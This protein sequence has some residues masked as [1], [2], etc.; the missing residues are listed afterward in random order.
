[1]QIDIGNIVSVV[2]GGLLVFAGHWFTSR[3]ST[4]VEMQKWKQEELREVR[5]DVVSFRE[6]RVKPI[7]EALDR[8]AHRWDAESH[9]ELAAIV[10]YHGE[11]VDVKSEKYKR[12]RHERRKKYFEQLKDDISAAS[13]IHDESVRRLVTQVLW[14]STEPE[15][16]PQFSERLQEAY[17]QLENWIFNPQLDYDSTRHRQKQRD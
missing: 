17:L 13:T 10:G 11:E 14:Q 4:K 7:I 2:I 6:E 1:M 15:A 16:E 8:A 12:K 5:R 3:Q 9:S